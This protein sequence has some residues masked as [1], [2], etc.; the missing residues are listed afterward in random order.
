MSD[1]LPNNEQVIGRPLDFEVVYAALNQAYDDYQRLCFELIANQDDYLYCVDLLKELLTV[2][3]TIFSNEYRSFFH[4]MYRTAPAVLFYLMQFHD[5]RELFFGTKSVVVN[6]RLLEKLVTTSQEY[7]KAADFLKLKAQNT[8]KSLNNFKK[9]IKNVKNPDYSSFELDRIA[10]M[11]D[12]LIESLKDPSKDVFFPN[13]NLNSRK[14]DGRTTLGREIKQYLNEEVG[15]F[16]WAQMPRPKAKRYQ[17]KDLELELES[18][19]SDESEI[20]YLGMSSISQRLNP[21]V[22]KVREDAMAPQAIGVT[23]IPKRSKQALQTL[24]NMEQAN[25]ALPSKEQGHNELASNELSSNGLVTEE[26]G[27]VEASLELQDAIEPNE[28]FFTSP[29]VNNNTYGVMELLSNAPAFGPINAN[30]T[31]NYDLPGLSQFQRKPHQ[32]LTVELKDKIESLGALIEKER[33]L[34]ARQIRR[35]SISFP[36]L[37]DIFGS[38]LCLV[39][40]NPNALGAAQQMLESWGQDCLI[41]YLGSDLLVKPSS[42]MLEDTAGDC[43]SAVDGTS[44]WLDEQ[45][46]EN[47]V[48]TTGLELKLNLSK[49]S[50][51]LSKRH[52][53]FSLKQTY[54]IWKKQTNLNKYYEGIYRIEV[55]DPDAM[56]I[57]I[58]SSTFGP[59]DLVY[60][61]L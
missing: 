29:M 33:A 31:R 43:H 16:D 17:R 35:L 18:E 8:N 5:A 9:L 4:I 10:M 38:R 59:Y 55:T 1:K 58:N 46:N 3:R 42:S 54:N 2:H 48:I 14:I 51:P 37:W 40:I 41:I 19:S 36:R 56:P 39:T 49:V 50:L 25:K 30:R 28:Q 60:I 27:S 53:S 44:S 34:M 26:R 11:D 15:E 24:E 61:K 21:K 22:L 7:E 32:I 47:F 57:V 13:I 20:D 12:G 52:K 6:Y 45:V 23:K